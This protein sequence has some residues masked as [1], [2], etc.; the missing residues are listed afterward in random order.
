MHGHND[1]NISALLDKILYQVLS[2]AFCLLLILFKL[3]I[4]HDPLDR[5]QSKYVRSSLCVFLARTTAEK[6]PGPSHAPKL[7]QASKCPI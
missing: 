4:C 3:V 2:I 7:M 6:T 1:S 5:W